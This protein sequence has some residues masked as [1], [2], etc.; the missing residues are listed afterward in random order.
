MRPRPTVPN[1]VF[2]TLDP[3]VFELG[4]SRW[5]FWLRKSWTR[6]SYDH[7]WNV[8]DSLSI[9]F[10][11]VLSGFKRPSVGA[12]WKLGEEDPSSGVVLVT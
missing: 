6:M 1:S 4:R 8:E 7:M 9:N 12:M 11:L 2:V 10:A 3:E 5:V